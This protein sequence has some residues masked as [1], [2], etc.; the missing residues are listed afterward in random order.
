MNLIII[1][2]TTD[3]QRLRSADDYN[4]GSKRFFSNAVFWKFHVTDDQ[5][6]RDHITR[7]RKSKRMLATYIRRMRNNNLE[8][9]I[10]GSSCRPQLTVLIW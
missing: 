4:Q 2:I 6:T 8:I 7:S 10:A 1:I 9:R 5:N 3:K